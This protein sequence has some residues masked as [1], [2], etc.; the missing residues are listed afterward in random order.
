MAVQAPSRKVIA[1]GVA[2]AVCYVILRVLDEAFGFKA[3]AE[4]AVALLTIVTFVG[5]YLIP[6]K[7]PA[8]PEEVT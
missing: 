5:Q 7:A 2:G 8:A 3:Q 4:D 1:G 6:N